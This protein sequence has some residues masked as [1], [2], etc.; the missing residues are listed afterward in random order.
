MILIEIIMSWL[1]DQSV[2]EVHKA[3]VRAAMLDGLEQL[4]FIV[5]Q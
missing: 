5:G 1:S 4:G 3:A 2:S